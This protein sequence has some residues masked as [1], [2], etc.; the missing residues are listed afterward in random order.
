MV[1]LTGQTYR[2]RFINITPNDA[3]VATS[4]TLDEHPVKWRAIA[5]DGADL[6]PQQATVQDALRAISVGET[7]D[8][9]FAPIAP[10]NYALRFCSVLGSEV[11]QMIAVVPPGSPF[12][13]Y[14]AKR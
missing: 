13:V 9:E 5:K 10:G 12:S 3:V 7:Y 4:L 8:Y 11:T 1:L 6:P 2:F 14:A